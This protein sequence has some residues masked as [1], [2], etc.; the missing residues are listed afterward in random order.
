ML[1]RG[2]HSVTAVGNKLYLFGGAPQN[3]GMLNDLWVLDTATMQW[4]ELH[5]E[6]ELPHKRCSHT[7][8]AM[9]TSI[10]FF[11]GSYYRCV[12]LTLSV[13]VTQRRLIWCGAMRHL[14][15]CAFHSASSWH[16][17]MRILSMLG[18]C[19]ITTVM[20]LQHTL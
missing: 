7:A 13:R 15:T 14:C 20:L 16:L 9:G 5:P 3:G 18:R 8:V 12:R 6:G 11:G 17:L 10:V 1:C 4:T 19:D 2:L